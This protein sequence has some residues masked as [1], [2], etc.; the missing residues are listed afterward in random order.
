MTYRDFM[1]KHGALVTGVTQP[2]IHRARHLTDDIRQAANLGVVRAL[3]A[4]EV[5]GA[6]AEDDVVSYVISTVRTEVNRVTRPESRYAARHE[7]LGEEGEEGEAFRV[8]DQAT[9][10][11]ELYARHQLDAA[12]VNIIEQLPTI[13]R[14]VATARFLND[15]PDTLAVVAVRLGI[16]LWSARHAENLARRRLLKLANVHRLID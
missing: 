5:L 15:P 7:P 11:S 2:A 6:T 9:S 13:Q 8:A 16:S 4:A 14:Q 1:L 12:L 3:D 10:A